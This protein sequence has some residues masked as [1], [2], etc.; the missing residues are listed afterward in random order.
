M[1]QRLV[2]VPQHESDLA[3][4]KREYELTMVDEMMDAID[5]L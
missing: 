1:M 4:Q 5:W 2:M 3:A